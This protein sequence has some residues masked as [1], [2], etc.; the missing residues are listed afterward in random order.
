[1]AKLIKFTD[2]RMLTEHRLTR[3]TAKKEKNSFFLMPRTAYETSNVIDSI[4]TNKTSHLLMLKQNFSKSAKM[5]LLE[6]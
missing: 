1:M 6:S 4:K 2:T 5:L 3:A